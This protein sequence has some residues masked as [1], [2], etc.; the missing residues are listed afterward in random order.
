MTRKQEILKVSETLI[1]EKGYVGLSMRDLAKAIGVKAASLYNHIP[2]KQAILTE[3][4]LQL[5]EDFTSQIQKVAKENSTSLDK[6]KK[7]IEHH[8]DL[9]LLQPNKL[10]I[11]NTEWIH[12][13]GQ[14]LL[15]FKLKRSQYEEALRQIINKGKAKQELKPLHTELVLFSMLSTLRNLNLWVQKR[16]SIPAE[17]L[18][19]EL[20]EVLLKGIS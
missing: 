8:V 4:I 6:L 19:N 7:I 12:L 13:E 11:L 9:S 1:R 14:A 15:D 5:A 16:S 3:L 10:A 17:Q 18:K 2:S 20:A